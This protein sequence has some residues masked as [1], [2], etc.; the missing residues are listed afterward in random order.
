M[1]GGFPLSTARPCLARGLVRGGILGD[2]LSPLCFSACVSE[3]H[4]PLS[5]GT[6]PAVMQWPLHLPSFL[7][8]LSVFKA[9]DCV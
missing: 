3:S 6:W 5:S 4:T 1:G 2:S 7:P 9:R 8:G